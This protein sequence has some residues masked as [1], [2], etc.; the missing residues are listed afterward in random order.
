MSGGERRRVE[1][2][3]SLI[4]NPNFLLLDEPFSGVDPV[5]VQEIQGIIQSLKKE[6]IGVLI[7]DHN[8]RETLGI[9]DRSYVL[10]DGKIIASGSPHMILENPEVRKQ[11]L[12]DKFTL[13]NWGGKMAIDI[14]QNLKLTQQLLMTP[15]LQQAIKLLQLSRL[16]LEQFISQQISENPLLE[17]TRAESSDDISSASGFQRGCFK[18]P[19]RRGFYNSR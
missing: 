17:D 18:E 13:L 7:T 12:G 3:R 14:R 1:I 16:E 2:A 15:Q 19:N 5:T 6:G 9:C 10:S 8:V 4:T 11:Y